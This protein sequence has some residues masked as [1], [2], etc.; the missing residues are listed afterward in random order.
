M[1]SVSWS[2]GRWSAPPASAYEQG[3]DLLVI[4]RSGS[5]LWR[6]TFYGFVHH[7]GHALLVP[8]PDA[9]AVEVGFRADLTYLYDQAGLL[10]RVDD[11]TWIKAGVE[12]T[13][14]AWHLGAVVTREV[15]DWSLAP[16]PEWEGQEVTIRASR[17]GN[18]VTIRARAGQEPWRLVRLAPLPEGVPVFAGPMCC[19]PQGPG[20]RVRFTRYA[21][22]PPDGD[23][24]TP[25][26]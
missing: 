23:L 18:A 4:A 16:V 6:T 21:V 15:S 9:A 25:P 10:L 11:E 7:D 19:S 13:D 3:R 24:H 8:M 5:D 14:G 20:A 22:G 26:E 17:S 1:R 2:A 12:R